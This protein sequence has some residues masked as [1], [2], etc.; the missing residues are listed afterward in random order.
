MEKRVKNPFAGQCRGIMIALLCCFCGNVLLYA[1][2]L[3]EPEENGEDRFIYD[4][5]E[6]P[7]PF[8]PLL[9]QSGKIK[10]AE[11]SEM[12][13]L[14]KRLQMITVNGVLWD[15][16]MPLLMINNKIYK[17]GDVTESGLLVSD[18][19]ADSIVLGYGKL[20]REISLVE[21]RKFE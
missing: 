8:V 1:Q 4:A 18:I 9:N 10:D 20:T 17:K 5:G 21:K 15:K 14:A 2:E 16:E 7:D 12:E 11:S 19:S 13:E 3:P 6:R